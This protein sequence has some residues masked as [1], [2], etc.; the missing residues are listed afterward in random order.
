MYIGYI[1]KVSSVQYTYKML[2]RCVYFLLSVVN[3][4]KKYTHLNFIILCDHV[5]WYQPD[6]ILVWSL[7]NPC[8]CNN[9]DFCVLLVVCVIHSCFQQD[10]WPYFNKPYNI[11]SKLTPKHVFEYLV[12]FTYFLETIY[13]LYSSNLTLLTKPKCSWSNP[14][15]T[16]FPSNLTKQFPDT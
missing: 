16:Q 3:D 2:Y 14:Q 9:E 6:V 4:N 12:N 5:A 10:S 1:G 15:K 11:Y 8:A 13:L 7:Y